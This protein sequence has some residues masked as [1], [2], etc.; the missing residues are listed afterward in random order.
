MTSG[1]VRGPQ[2]FFVT[3]V[4]EAAI[5][6]A[7]EKLGGD[8]VLLDLRD[9][10]ETLDAIVVTSGRN[11]RQVRAIAD[12]IEHQVERSLDVKPMRVE[13]LTTGEWVAIDYGDVIIHVFLD[14]AREYYDLEHLWSAA[15]TYRP[16][17]QR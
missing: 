8:T 4:L 1:Y 11:D 13:G 14:A 17:L 3:A 7:D 2:S 10:Q 5:L 9:L 6:G 15:P 12:E 16:Q